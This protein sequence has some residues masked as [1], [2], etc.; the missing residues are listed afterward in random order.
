M[1]D[2][3]LAERCQALHA[4]YNN[5]TRYAYCP[6]DRRIVEE[7]AFLQGC[8]PPPLRLCI[9]RRPATPPD[10]SPDDTA[11]DWDEYEG[12]HGFHDAQLASSGR[13]GGPGMAAMEFYANFSIARHSHNLR[14]MRRWIDFKGL[15]TAVDV[16]GGGGHMASALRSDYGI[17]CLTL[18]RDNK[19]SSHWHFDLPFSAMVVTRGNLALTWSGTHRLPVPDRSIDFFHSHSAVPLSLDAEVNEGMLLDWDRMLR[20]GGYVALLSQRTDFL[21]DNSKAHHEQAKL[22][23]FQRTLTK[24]S[25]MVGWQ[26]LCPRFCV[27]PRGMPAKTLLEPSSDTAELKMSGSVQARLFRKP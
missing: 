18:T 19:F 22:D 24:V 25:K 26:D 13:L 15:H 5:Y 1:T 14:Q 17:T 6:P 20:P 3:T 4:T 16:G 27:W 10:R 8:L 2:P 9:P 12:L 11:V 23:G 7:I 21:V